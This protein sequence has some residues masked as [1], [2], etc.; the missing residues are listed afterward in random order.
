MNIRIYNT[1][2]KAKEDFQPIEAGKVGMYLCGPTVY[3]K[4][5]IGHMV[6]PIIF[7]AVKRFLRYS[8]FDVNFVVNITD[9][10]DKLINAANKRGIPMEQV[11][12]EMTKDYLDNLAAVGVDT[13]DEMPKATDHIGEIIQFVEE[14][15]EKD[16]AYAVDGDVFFDVA[17]D[18]DYGK[19]SNRSAE[20]QQGEGG[21]AAAKKRSSSDF[22][23]WKAAKE[24]E[25]AWDS[26]WGKGRPGWHIECSAMSRKSLGKT[27]DI[28]GG[29]LDLVFPHHENELAQSES[30]HGQPMV[31]Y[32]MHNGLLRRAAAGKL[33]GKS[34]RPE[35]ESG[36]VSRSKGDGGLAELIARQTGER[37]RFFLLQTHYRSTVEFSEERIEETG[38]AMQA[39][40][41]FFERY[42]RV[43]GESFFD[44]TPI[45]LRSEGE[46]EAGDNALLQLVAE[47]RTGFLTKMDD[48]FN[49]GAAIS[50]LFELARALNKFVDEKDLETAGS[51]SDESMATLKQGV[52]TL[53][54][55][56]TVLGLFREAP[57]RD[58]SGDNEIV[59]GLMKL[60]IEIRANAR[61][62]KDYATS[63]QIRDGLTSVG[64]TLEDRKDET[65][66]RVE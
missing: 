39:F 35:G 65:L 5:H 51:R 52:A 30:C 57:A 11:A 61:Q 16:A 28:H 1:L 41:R 56:T 14:L 6:G 34:D 55:L 48:D 60:I 53:R 27:F 8:G 9:V 54:E 43:T 46:I 38:A 62:N 29:G 44:I 33:G 3:D 31:K 18:N 50:E 15:I 20:D 23:L 4:A 64:I 19:L 32:W 42:E 36:K 58:A 49:T 13:I 24:G 45:E 59:A 7:D 2:S 10:D 66:W 17:A 12:D 40:T 22:A 63:D 26:P 47:R 25:P 37:I 21:G